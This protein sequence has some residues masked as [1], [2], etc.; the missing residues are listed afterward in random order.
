MTASIRC[1]QSMIFEQILSVSTAI[2]QQRLQSRPTKSIAVG[3][4]SSAVHRGIVA[5]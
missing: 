2:D 1:P 3:D 5:Q 4:A